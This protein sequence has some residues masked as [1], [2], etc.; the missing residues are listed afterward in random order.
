MRAHII[1][2]ELTIG[3]VNQSDSALFYYEES[4]KLKK[5]INDVKGL[6]NTL[7]NIGQLYFHKEEYDKGLKY[8]LEALAIDRKLKNEIGIYQS[9]INIGE[10]YLKTGDINSA[11]FY[12]NSGV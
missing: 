11:L 10:G 3:G 2:G 12:L 7:A 8:N 1:I 5:I 4:V 6:A 9:Y